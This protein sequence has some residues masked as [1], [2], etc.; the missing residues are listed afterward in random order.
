MKKKYLKASLILCFMGILLIIF[1]LRFSEQ[2]KMTFRYH[3]IFFGI[4]FGIF[5]AGIANVIRYVY[6]S[7]PSKAPIYEAKLKTERILLQ[8]ERKIMLRAKA[9]QISYQVMFLVLFTINMI[10]SFTGVD[11]WVIMTLWGVILFQYGLG[12][13]VFRRLSKK[14]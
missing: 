14:Y 2:L 1:S 9:G 12:V 10:F 3:T 11:V 5:T 13:Y 7:L 8:D 4:G 6:W